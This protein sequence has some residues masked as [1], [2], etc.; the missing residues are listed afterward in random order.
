MH[1]YSFLLFNISTLC[2]KFCISFCVWYSITL[3]SKS[4]SSDIISYYNAFLVASNL[5]KDITVKDSVYE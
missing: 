4:N 5:I 2:S 1:C 3:L